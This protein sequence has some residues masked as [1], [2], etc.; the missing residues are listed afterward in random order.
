MQR[1]SL[2]PRWLDAHVQS[3]KRPRSC[4]SNKREARVL[5]T[6]VPC[7]LSDELTSKN[8]KNPPWPTSYYTWYKTTSNCFVQEF[9]LYDAPTKSLPDCGPFAADTILTNKNLPKDWESTDLEADTTDNDCPTARKPDPTKSNY[10][11][12]D[13]VVPT[14]EKA[15]MEI[16]NST[17]GEEYA[18]CRAKPDSTSWIK[19]VFEFGQT[20]TLQCGM[21]FDTK[22][23]GNSTTV[24]K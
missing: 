16:N 19:K 17:I 9:N 8:R 15:K 5:C 11:R 7:W 20:V 10:K 2:Y 6:V 18:P 24:Q 21:A 14:I 23:Y 3:R 22:P 4:L 1:R 13:I 12:S